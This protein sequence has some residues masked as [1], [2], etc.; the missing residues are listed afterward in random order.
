ML[1]VGLLFAGVVYGQSEVAEVPLPPEWMPAYE[2]DVSAF[3]SIATLPYIDLAVPT[4]VEVPLAG[5]VPENTTAVVMSQTNDAGPARYVTRTFGTPVSAIRA[6]ARHAPQDPL[7]DAWNSVSANPVQNLVDNN[8][9]TVVTFDHYETS[10]D[11]VTIEL[12]Y[13]EAITTDTLRI[14]LAQYVTPP[15]HVRIQAVTQESGADEAAMRDV[16]SNRT[17]T[18][19]TI[20]FPETTARQF[21]VTLTYAQ[22]LRVSEVTFEQ[23]GVAQETRAVRYLAQPGVSYTLYMDPDRSYGSVST[24]GVMLNGSEDVVTY[25]GVAM[26]V[27]NQQFAAADTDGDGVVDEKDN[28]PSVANE[29]QE[30]ANNN[31]RGDACDD[32]DRDGRMTSRDNCPDTP[33]RDQRDTDGDGV[34]DACDLEESRFTEANPWV[35]WVGIGLAGAVLVGLMMLVVRDL[36]RKRDEEVGEE[37]VASEEN[38]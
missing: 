9:G 6:E 25:E 14:G 28:C 1:C 12:A 10:E 13:A 21:V 32:H 3:R 17:Y 24:G 8:A 30:D 7:A 2:V 26:L 15:T 38:V 37:K 34:G 20:R 31:G 11:V 29:L 35:P 36:G 19:G 5:D 33:N 4:V 16:V 22:Q 23:Q 27:P 18:G